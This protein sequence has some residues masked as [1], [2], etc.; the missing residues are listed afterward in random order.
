MPPE[1]VGLAHGVQSGMS[2]RGRE[3]RVLETLIAAASLAILT[4]GPSVALSHLYN[5]PLG[6]E[7]WPY[8]VPMGIVALVAVF[9]CGRDIGLDALRRSRWPIGLLTGY[10]LWSLASVRWSVAPDA[11]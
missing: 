8:I 7:R 6:W 5:V 1:R 11:T 9:L 3:I 2:R 4:N 10:L